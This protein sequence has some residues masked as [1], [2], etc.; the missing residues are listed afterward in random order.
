MCGIDPIAKGDIKVVSGGHEG[1]PEIKPSV[2][3]SPRWDLAW[4]LEQR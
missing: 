1:I 4:E 2:P 3:I